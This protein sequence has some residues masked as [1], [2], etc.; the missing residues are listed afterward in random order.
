ML[1]ENSKWI[2]YPQYDDETVCPVFRKKFDTQGKIKKAILKITSLGCYFAELGG[3]R[4]GDFIFAPGWTFYKRVQLQEYDVTNLISNENELRV[5]I[6]SGW[7]KGRINERNRKELKGTHPAFICELEIKFQNGEKK[8]LVSDDTWECSLSKITM[9]D[10]YDGEHY[11]ANFEEKFGAVALQD[12][13]FVEIIKQQGEKI[14]EQ[15]TLHAHRIFTT[16]KGE[17]VIDFNQNLT[18]YFE[19]DLVAK[20]GE[21][22]S[23]SFAEVLDKDGNFYTENYRSAKAEFEY[24]CKDGRQNYKPK[25][26]FWGFRYVRVN[27]FPCELTLDSVKAIVVHSDIKRTGYLDSSSPLLN[28]LFKNIIWGQKGNFLDIPTDCPQRDE[29]LGWTGD[30][31]VFVKTASYNY[32]VEKFFEKWLADLWLEQQREGLIPFVVPQ[33]HNRPGSSTAAWSDASTV[34]PW[35]IYLTYGNRD[36]LKKQFKSMCTYVSEI[37]KI[38]KKKDL[39]YGC[40]HFGDWLGLDAPVGSYVGSSNFDIIGTAFYAYSTSLVVKAGKVLGKNV[41]KYEKLYERIINKAKKTFTEYNTQTECV[42]ALYFGLT[43]D[44]AKVAK[45][46]ATMIEENGKRLKTGFVGTPYLLHALSQNGYIDLAYDLLLQEKYPSWLYSVKQGATTVWEHWDGINDKGEFWSKDMNSFNH[47]AY[48]SVA[49]WVYGVACGI[50]TV[51]EYPGFEKIVI[52]PNPT[53]KLDW[54]SAK[55]ETRYGTLSSAWY[56]EGDSFRYEITTPSETT[57]MIDGKEHKIE[58]GTYIF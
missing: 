56:K 7:Y 41:S 3:Q 48:G 39:W 15:D 57:V 23:F 55:I 34:C 33:V 20:K 42:L 43:D 19:I 36:I 5:T 16:P 31:Q 32:D 17:V 52:A 50:Q 47:Y 37:G 25:L 12:C 54:L 8:I 45:K 51:E 58:K 6:G 46:L 14:I 28:K 38:T 11:D 22:V 44:K 40:W 53:E 18:G 29:R 13:S 30:A 21:R 1:L 26:A 49:D 10:I 24:I 4:I 9:S 2:T 27:S 35:Q